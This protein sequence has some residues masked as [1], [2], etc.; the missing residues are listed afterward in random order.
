MV[1][2]KIRAHLPPWALLEKVGIYCKCERWINEKVSVVCTGPIA[3]S[4]HLI[5]S[6]LFTP[7]GQVVDATLFTLDWP[8][9]CQKKPV[10]Y[11]GSPVQD[12]ATGCYHQVQFPLKMC[13]CRQ[14]IVLS[15]LNCVK[16]TYCLSFFSLYFLLLTEHLFFAFS[17]RRERV[18]K[19]SFC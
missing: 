15:I 12:L 13:L 19:I 10:K 14:P 4:F 3:K 7:S 6:Y 5:A 2:M 8:P 17:K 9:V 18:K 1:I 16:A 11:H